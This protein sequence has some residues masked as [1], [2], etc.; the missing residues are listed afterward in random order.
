MTYGL[1]GIQGLL[2]A[3]AGSARLLLGP[4]LI[5]LP[6]LGTLLPVR[7]WPPTNSCIANMKRAITVKHTQITV[8][9]I[10]GRRGTCKLVLPDWFRLAGV[11]YRNA[12]TL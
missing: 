12:A 3:F 10:E 1:W 7:S 4:G 6:I 11:L 9:A 2:L 8:A 5:V